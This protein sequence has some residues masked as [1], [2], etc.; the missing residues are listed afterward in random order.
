MLLRWSSRWARLPK[1]SLSRNSMR[2]LSFS[3]GIASQS[4]TA[5]FPF[6]VI[7]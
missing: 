1:H 6:S 7:E 4:K 2:A 5:D 3:G